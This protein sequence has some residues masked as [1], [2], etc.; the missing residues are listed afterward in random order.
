MLPD[1]LTQRVC[2]IAAKFRLAD[3]ASR[4]VLH[5]VSQRRA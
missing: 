2:A 4:L 1:D 3:E 5:V